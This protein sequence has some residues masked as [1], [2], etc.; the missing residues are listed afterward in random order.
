MKKIKNLS[1]LVIMSSMLALS[2][3]TV[4]HIKK[5]PISAMTCSTRDE[6]VS[7]I[8]EEKVPL[9]IEEFGDNTELTIAMGNN[10][11]TISGKLQG[12]DFNYKVEEV[13]SFYLFDAN[14]DGYRDLCYTKGNTNHSVTI[15]DLKA[16]KDIY[17]INGSFNKDGYWLS[18]ENDKLWIHRDNGGQTFDETK[19]KGF[20]DYYETRGVYVRWENY[21]KLS[22]FVVDVDD[23]ESKHEYMVTSSG[24]IN[25][26]QMNSSKIYTFWIR[27]FFRDDTAK[28]SEK[29][30]TH[31]SLLSKGFLAKS[32]GEPVEDEYNGVGFSMNFNVDET[33]KGKQA[34]D[35]EVLLSGCSTIL[36]MLFDYN[37]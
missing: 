29:T 1:L 4:E 17:Y 7:L 15:Y 9:A 11:T 20:F 8:G 24:M 13:H 12:E 25:S 28:V 37:K 27:P 30:N 32:E 18:L 31:F 35:F 10:S 33:V 2:G 5:A 34:V 16:Q 23:G 36:R 14:K 22:Y 6:M 19:D 21:A 26:I 3:C